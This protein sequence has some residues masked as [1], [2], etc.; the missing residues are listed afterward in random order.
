MS[1]CHHLTR[2]NSITAGTVRNSPPLGQNAYFHGCGRV[3]FFTPV[4]MEW[5]GTLRFG[6]Q[7]SS[8]VQWWGNSICKSMLTHQ[9]LRDGGRVIS[10]PWPNVPITWD[11]VAV[12]FNTLFEQTTICEG[13]Q[14]RNYFEVSAIVKFNNVRVLHRFSL[15][16]CRSHLNIMVEIISSQLL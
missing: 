12:I 6:E 11:S 13:G 4:T 8:T 2:L 10:C 15:A 7:L 9:V 16:I 1:V 3:A 5:C 14:I